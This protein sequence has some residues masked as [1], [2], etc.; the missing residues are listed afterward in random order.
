[1]LPAPAASA[2]HWI[3][4]TESQGQENAWKGSMELQLP[5]TAQGGEGGQGTEWANRKH[6]AQLKPSLP[7][8]MATIYVKAVPGS[9]NKAN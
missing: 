6:Q 9:Q 1:M 4:P 7:L 2:S 3:N 5:G 8:K